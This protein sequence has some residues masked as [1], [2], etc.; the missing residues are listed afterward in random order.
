MGDGYRSISDRLLPE[1][2]K[3]AGGRPYMFW[4]FI[5]WRRE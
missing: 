1:G 4:L 3:N 5:L 2:R